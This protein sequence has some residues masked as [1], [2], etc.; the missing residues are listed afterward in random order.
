MKPRG[1]EQEFMHTLRRLGRAHMRNVLKGVSRG[2]FAILVSLER[3]EERHK[4]EG[5]KAS[6][7]AELVEASPQALSRTLRGLEA[8]GY[9]ERRV[10][11]RDRRNACI[12]LTGE[13]RGVMEAGKR[14]MSEFFNQVVNAMGEEEVRELISRLNR[15]VEVM[16]EIGERMATTEEAAESG[17][18]ELGKE[19]EDA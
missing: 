12:C 5:L 7:L 11:S 3:Y 4:G 10:D 16:N 2:E 6:V 1:L 17:V 18:T 9:I 14:Q 19:T 15:L 13:A 8:K